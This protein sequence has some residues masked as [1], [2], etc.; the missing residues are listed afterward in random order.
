MDRHDV[1]MWR[2]QHGY[3][4]S[5]LAV[6]IGVDARTLARWERGESRLPAWLERTLRDIDTHPSQDEK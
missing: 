6:L 1:T 2:H 5:Q 3:T 4:R